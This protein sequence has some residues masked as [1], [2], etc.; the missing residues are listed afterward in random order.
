MTAFII[1]L[2]PPLF[3]GL[4]PIKKVKE[5]LSFILLKIQN[6]LPLLRMLKMVNSTDPVETMHYAAS[7]LGQRY[8]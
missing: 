2:R 4:A 3:K 6:Y 1:A 7:H 5:V 8:L